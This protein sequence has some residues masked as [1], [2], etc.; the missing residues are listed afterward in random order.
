MPN[1]QTKAA[2]SS[3]RDSWRTRYSSSNHR[4]AAGSSTSSISPVVLVAWCQKLN[5]SPH[6][7]TASST[8]NRRCQPW[9]RD[10]SRGHGS[11]S[12][13]RASM[14]SVT[15]AVVAE[16]RFRQNG[17]H[18]PGNS[19]RGSVS[20]QSSGWPTQGVTSQPAILAASGNP[21][22][23]TPELAVMP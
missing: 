6:T 15:A 17:T 13:E 4:A 9:S 19:R 22:S 3:Q 10:H 23:V 11:N 8:G 21:V 1:P 16:K 2:A 20:S 18:A 12:T 14:P 7:A 5:S